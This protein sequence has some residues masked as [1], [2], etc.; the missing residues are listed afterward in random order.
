MSLQVKHMDGNIFEVSCRGHK[1]VVDQPLEEGGSDK[2]MSPI[3]LFNAS[4]ATCIAYYA[5]TFLRRRIPN[6]QGLTVKTDWQYADNPHRIV[7]IHLSL[8]VPHE[9]AGPEAKGLQRY[10]ES[11][12]IGNTLRSVPKINITIASVK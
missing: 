6:I 3:E 4:L 11:S 1:I 12:T 9:L 2:G 10:V 8:N 5:V 7:A